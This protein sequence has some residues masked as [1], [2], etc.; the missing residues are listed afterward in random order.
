MRLDRARGGTTFDQGSL[1]R[2]LTWVLTGLL[3]LGIIRRGEGEQVVDG[4][5]IEDRPSVGLIRGV[6]VLSYELD[7]GHV[8]ELFQELEKEER[9]SVVNQVLCRRYLGRRV[10]R[11]LIDVGGQVLHVLFGTATDAQIDETRAD[12]AV[13][14]V[15]LNRLHKETEITRRALRDQQG[16]LNKTLRLIGKKELVNRMIRLCSSYNQL[17]EDAQQNEIGMQDWDEKMMKEKVTEFKLKT[18]LRPL[19]EINSLSFRASIQSMVRGNTIILSIPFID[20]RLFEHK[21]L[22]P[23]PIFVNKSSYEIVLNHRNIIFTNDEVGFLD[24]SVLSKCIFVQRVYICRPIKILKKRMAKENLCEI[25]VVF[26][27]IRKN[28]KFREG[29][30]TA[31]IIQG[32]KYIYIV[33]E[34]GESMTIM[35]GRGIVHKEVGSTGILSIP[36]GCS[37][38]SKTM[39]YQ[40]IKEMRERTEKI[41]LAQGIV[42]L[43]SVD[44]KTRK[45]MIEGMSETEIPMEDWDV[46]I[47]DVTGKWAWALGL[48]GFVLGIGGTI[49]T[50]WGIENRRQGNKKEKKENHWELLERLTKLEEREVEGNKKGEVEKEEEGE[51]AEV[52]KEI[53]GEKA[54][55]EK[56]VII[57]REGSFTE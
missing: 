17:R 45:K 35:C 15:K 8:T 14:A 29:P 18:G 9:R 10:K 4:I 52:E 32:K 39:N 12:M 16:V 3:V 25:D 36:R 50:W 27:N 41:D 57:V 20:D 34:P 30:K 1:S 37:F 43:T 42:Q 54:E 19:G 53:E 49:L 31:K 40:D 7:V 38:W 5:L 23:V 48:L 2:G 22:T 56:R 46:D 26:E 13:E 21:R 6:L 51:K 44:N 33:E 47:L 55:G 24:K 28:C 11:G